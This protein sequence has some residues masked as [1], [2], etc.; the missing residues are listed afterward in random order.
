[1]TKWFDHPLLIMHSQH[2]FPERATSHALSPLGSRQVQQYQC[3]VRGR[4]TA[5]YMLPN[6]GMQCCNWS[7]GQSA[8]LSKRN[9]KLSASYSR[10]E[11]PTFPL[12]RCD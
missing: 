7:R 11:T 10:Y 12:C 5:K 9:K 3:S 2:L 8:R 6:V 4:N 1:M